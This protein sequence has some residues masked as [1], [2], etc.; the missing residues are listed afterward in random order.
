MIDGLDLTLDAVVSFSDP[1][2]LPRVAIPEPSFRSLQSA[3]AVFGD[4]CRTIGRRHW[5][6]A[7]VDT[8]T[9]PAYLSKSRL[10]TGVQR[11]VNES[12]LVAALERQGVDILYPETMSFAEQVKLFAQ[13]RVV[14]GLTGSAFH[15]APFS[16]PA[17]RT[18]ALSG[19]LHLH[20]NYILFDAINR[21][22]AH[23]YFTPGTTTF[24][25]NGFGVGWKIP[26]PG[27]VAE[28]MAR[29]AE[30]IDWI[31]RYDVEVE[32]E[33]ERRGQ[34]LTGRLHRLR[35]SLLARWKPG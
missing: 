10:P 7:E 3:H 13:R 8:V 31:E 1:V 9:R 26:D 16:A 18:I 25:E 17:R 5:T 21:N 2:M 29:R 14:M 27:R 23:Y 15:T 33:A 22:H 35:R 24:A 12:N 19:M 30:N 34:S 28:Q 11:L 20:A 6:E 4:L 32:A